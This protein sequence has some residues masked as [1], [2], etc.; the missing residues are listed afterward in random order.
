MVG[1]YL[2][3]VRDLGSPAYSGAALPRTYE[4]ARIA[5]DTALIGGL[6]IAPVAGRAAADGNPP[7]LEGVTAARA[8]TAGGCLRAAPT[9]REG[10]VRVVL[11]PT[12][13]FVDPSP[14]HTTVGLR[15]WNDTFLPLAAGVPQNGRAFALRAPPDALGGP[16]H[17][18]LDVVG[19]VRLCGAAA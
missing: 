4:A 11:P 8:E 19:P 3:A 5:A 9:G 10:R 1:P 12:G 14:G 18:E 6:P 2:A 7:A 17:V 16:W 15:R 13:L